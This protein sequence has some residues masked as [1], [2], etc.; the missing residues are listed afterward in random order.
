MGL[1]N[2]T[3]DNL[4]DVMKTE[5]LDY[6]RKDCRYKEFMI[7]IISDAIKDKLGKMNDEVLLKLSVC[8]MNKL[9]ICEFDL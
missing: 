7:Q 9:D 2:N 4:A 8:V 1:S 6:I 5:V 3:Y